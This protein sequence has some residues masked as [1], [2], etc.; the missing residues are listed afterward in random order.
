MQRS[1]EDMDAGTNDF[2]FPQEWLEPLIYGLADRLADEYGVDN[3]IKGRIA[4]RAAESL[5][6]AMSFDQEEGSIFFS[7]DFTSGPS[8]VGGSY[9]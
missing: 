4:R 1:F 2:D 6:L 3:G 8:N 5:A 7:P 9:D